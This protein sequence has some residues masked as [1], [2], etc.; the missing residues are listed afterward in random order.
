MRW[1]GAFFASWAPK[2]LYTRALIIIIAPIVILQSIL[3]FVFLDRHW[4][5][6]TGRLSVATAQD[7]AMLADA[8]GWAKDKGPG[9]L[10]VEEPAF[11]TADV[12]VHCVALVRQREGEHLDLGELVDAINAARGAAVGAGLRAETVAQAADL[13]RQ[14]LGVNN[15]LGQPAAERDLGR[16]DQAQ[17][18]I[19]NAVNLRFRTTRDE[20]DAFEHLIAGQVGVI[21]GV[22]PSA[23][24]TSR[25]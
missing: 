5:V 18:A 22:K 1:L 6:V 25:A 2:G 23:K 14:P 12:F 11:Q 8:Y 9:E 10:A 17:V 4:Q 16:G 13:D 24:S 3:T 20:A 21:I 19:F 7:I 15:L